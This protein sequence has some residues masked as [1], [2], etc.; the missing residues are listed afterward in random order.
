MVNRLVQQFGLWC[1]LL[2]VSLPSLGKDTYHWSIGPSLPAPVQEIYPTVHNDAIYV[3]GGLQDQNS[4][5]RVSNA[6]YRLKKGATTWETLPPFP[7]AAHHVMLVSTGAQLWAFGG[8]TAS[9]QGSWANSAQV[10]LFDE[11]SQTW[12]AHSSMPVKLSET[13]AAVIMGDVH[14]AGGRTTKSDNF[15]WRH[16]LDSDWHG[17]FDTTAGIWQTAAP[18]PSARNSACSVV[19]AGKWHVIGGRTVEQGN[20][21]AHDIFDPV[22]DEWIEAKPLPV[23]AGG[24]GCARY[25]DSIYV[26]GGEYFAK[27]GS[28]VFSKVWRYEIKRKRWR[29]VSVM[30]IPRHG[31][32]VV[33]F[34]G[35]MWLIGGAGEAG[36]NDTRNTVSKLVLNP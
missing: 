13:I 17:V 34:D 29:D 16:H 27:S 7:V 8:F 20:T 28:G 2:C 5:F 14:L 35:A 36:A 22:E 9:A 6:V 32:G 24:I 10:Y 12:H 23:A 21:G 4:E 31:L 3:V 1:V 18:L 11:V 30:P 15:S 25:G 26:F 33:T 19:I